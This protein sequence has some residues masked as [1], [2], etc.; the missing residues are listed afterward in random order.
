M[1]DESSDV[2]VKERPLNYERTQNYIL[3][4]EPSLEELRLQSK[5]ILHCILYGDNSTCVDRL[6]RE[7]Y[8]YTVEILAQLE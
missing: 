4:S 7:L 5:A 8:W 1:E 2:L 3:A 6:L